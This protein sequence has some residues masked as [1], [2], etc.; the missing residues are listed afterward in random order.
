[1]IDQ[2]ITGGN[3]EQMFSGRRQ[4]MVPLKF[5]VS[6]DGAAI[7]EA[8]LNRVAAGLSDTPIMPNSLSTRRSRDAA[9]RDKNFLQWDRPHDQ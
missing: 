2:G 1:M 7:L 8:A 4:G 6:G 5:H 3:A 9:A